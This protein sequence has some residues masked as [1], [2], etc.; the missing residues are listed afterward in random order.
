MLKIRIIG[1]PEEVDKATEL[2][3]VVLNVESI[4]KDYPSRYSKVDKRVYIDARTKDLNQCVIDTISAIS[5]VNNKTDYILSIYNNPAENSIG[6]I[7][8]GT[9]E[10]A[11]LTNIYSM[12]DQFKKESMETINDYATDETAEI[13]VDRVVCDF[14]QKVL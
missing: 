1:T 6:R 2:L 13:L 14:L 4:S 5:N 9:A 8:V 12:T 7:S 10:G 3:S 11:V